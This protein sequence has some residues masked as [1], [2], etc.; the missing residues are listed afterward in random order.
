[1][2]PEPLPAIEDIRPP[3]D[4]ADLLIPLIGT[5]FHVADVVQVKD[6]QSRHY[7]Q[8][9]TLGDIRHGKAHGFYMLEGTK[10]EFVTV[11][12][13]AIHFIG[14]AKVRAR[15]ACSPKWIADNQ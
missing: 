9:F 2:A 3:V 4:P 5:P 13:E 1:M 12:M 11:P 10:K 6:P 14:R 8:F 15:V 7:G